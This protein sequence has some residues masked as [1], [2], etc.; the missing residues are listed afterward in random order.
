MMM[1]T[2]SIYSSFFSFDSNQSL[3]LRFGEMKKKKEP[4]GADEMMLFGMEKSA[5]GAF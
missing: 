1:C 4:G 2:Y 5:C 3:S